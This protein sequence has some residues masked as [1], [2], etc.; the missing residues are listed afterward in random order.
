MSVLL[1]EESLSLVAFSSADELGEDSGERR[2]SAAS[3]VACSHDAAAAAAA[4]LSI[5][6]TVVA[7]SVVGPEEDLRTIAAWQE[8]ALS[9]P[10]SQL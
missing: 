8:K 6:G 3:S 2:N 5:S 10:E 9:F 1:P 4:E 7:A